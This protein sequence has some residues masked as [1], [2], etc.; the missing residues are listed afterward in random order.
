MA[1][2]DQEIVDL[3]EDMRLNTRQPW[4]LRRVNFEV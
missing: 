4:L 3:K 1:T 2:L